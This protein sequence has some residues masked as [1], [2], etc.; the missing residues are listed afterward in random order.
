[1]T[2]GNGITNFSNVKILYSP[3]FLNEQYKPYQKKILFYS[4]ANRSSVSD[5]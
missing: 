4:F 1:M 3:F 5:V 2:C